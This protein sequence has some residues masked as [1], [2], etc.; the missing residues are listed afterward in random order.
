MIFAVATALITFDATTLCAEPHPWLPPFGLERVG[1]GDTAFQAEAT[2]SAQPLLNPVDLGAIL[3]PQGWLLIGPEQTALATIAAYSREE[4]QQNAIVRAW[5]LSAPADVST[6][7]FPLRKGE[8]VQK[9]FKIPK[10]PVKGYRDTLRIVIQ[11]RAVTADQSASND[12]LWQKDVP[13]MIVRKPP[14]WPRFGATRTKL[15]Y[16]A[17]ISVRNSDNT[18][19]TLEYEKAWREELDDVV[20]SLPSGERF[21]FWRGASYVPFWASRYNTALSYEWAETTPPKDAFADCVEPLMDKELR[22]GRVEIVE[23]TPARVRVRWSYQSC[24]FLYKVWGDTAVE[25]FCF[26]P[27]GFGTRTLTL[28]ST[29]DGNYELSEFII[30]TPQG[31]YPFERLPSNLV[32]IVFLDGQKRELKFPYRPEEQAEKLK[33]R[34]MPAVYRVRLNREDPRAAVYFHPNDLK[35]PPVVFAPFSDAGKTVTPCY[36]GSHWPLARG[37]TTGGAINDR[38]HSTPAHNSVMSW[39]FQRPPPLREAVVQT[40]DSLGRAAPMRVQTWSWLIGMTGADDAALLDVAKSF[41]SPPS[42]SKLAGARLD[43]E[44]FVHERRA[45][46]LVAEA[47]TIDF[48]LVPHPVTVNP[49]FEI[50]DARAKLLRVQIN[51]KELDPLHWAWDGSTLWIETT[52]KTE[53]RLTLEFEQ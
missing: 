13:V 1:Q 23:S 15:R 29:L 17:S 26:Y 24:D 9:E 25:E 41:S 42:I 8:R 33:S 45:L 22:Y 21:V 37:Q 36:W 51:G 32:D 5:F 50:S 20:V 52:A 44:P 16:D 53:T 14:A 6:T 40:I 27:D 35:L 18:Y 11:K 31:A 30:L 47:A 38:I 2:V 48:V 3:P 43:D 4:D 34:E 49:A 46:R 19:S 7:S 39:A 12:V 28:Q 10:L